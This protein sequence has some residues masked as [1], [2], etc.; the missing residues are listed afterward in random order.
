MDLGIKIPQS[1]LWKIK[2]LELKI[3]MLKKDFDIL[4]LQKQNAILTVYVDYKL[5]RNANI[6]PDGTVTCPDPEPSIMDQM[7]IQQ[8]N[9]VLIKDSNLEYHNEGAV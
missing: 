3:E 8:D 4:N 2:E 6:E 9:S 7:E 1:V 5:P